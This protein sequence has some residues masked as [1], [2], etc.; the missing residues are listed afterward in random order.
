[1]RRFLSRLVSD[2]RTT[3]TARGTRRAPRRAGLCVEGLEDRMVLSTATQVGSALQV[4]ADAGFF[5]AAGLRLPIVAHIRQITFQADAVQH[6][7]LDVIDNGALLGRFAIASVKSVNVSVAGLDAVNINDSN[8]LPFAA[9]TN[10]SLFGSGILNSLSLA[11]SR[12]ISGG[13]TYVAGN[14]SLAGSLSLAGVAIQFSST[15]GSVSDTVKTTAPLFVT[16]SGSDVSLSGSNGVTQTLSGLGSAGGTLTYGNKNMVELDMFANEADATLSATKGATGEQFFVL[17]MHGTNCDA[18]INAT[19]ATVTTSVVL[20]G[21]ETFAL[22]HANSGRVSIAGTSTNTVILSEVVPNVGSTT[23]FIKANVSVNGV[24]KLIVQDGGNHSTQEH[25]TVTESTVSGTGLFGSSAVKLSYSNVANMEIDTGHL[26]NA[27]T[28][29]GSRP[30]ATFGT[31]ITLNDFSEAR[32]NVLV[33]LDSGSHLNVALLNTFATH[34][35]PA[36]LFISA[37]HGTFSH[38]TPNLPAGIEDVFF[39]GGLTS[40]VVYNGFTSVTHS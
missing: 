36:S 15:I 40:E 16:S 6:G 17:V 20:S 29:V 21:P 31:K 11:G 5:R 26:A 22:V 4:T 39:A 18:N 25:V 27:Y 3:K 28:F 24:G 9:G 2:F 33:A 23:A 34:P 14:G 32:L 19:P 30:G 35:A 12:T 13:E 37:P 7:K 38:P 1:M 8:G 10:V